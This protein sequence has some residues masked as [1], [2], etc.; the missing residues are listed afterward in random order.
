MRAYTVIHTWVWAHRQSYDVSGFVMMSLMM[1]QVC[2]D[3]TYDVSGFVMM[4]LVMF[5]DM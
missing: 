3:V 5:Q 4:S 1:F 2:D